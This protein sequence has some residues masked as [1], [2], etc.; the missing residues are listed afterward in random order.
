MQPLN[1]LQTGCRAGQPH[2]LLDVHAV[3]GVCFTVPSE[4]RQYDASEGHSSGGF[5]NVQTKAGTNQF[6]G[7]VFGYYQNPKINANLW[8]LS[9][10]TSKP[11]FVREGFGV[12]GLIL[13]GPAVLLRRL[14]AQ[15]PRQPLKS[16][17]L[18]CLPRP[19]EM[20]TSPR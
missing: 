12:G 18:R 17:R 3:D 16:K 7:S 1:R 13:P 14:R 4:H 10:M 9:R 19:R 15:P 11:T 5:V 2:S 20:A 6:H 8:S